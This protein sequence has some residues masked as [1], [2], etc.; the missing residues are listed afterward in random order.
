MRVVHC[1]V[2]ISNIAQSYHRMFWLFYISSIIV[3]I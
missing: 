2:F 3:G 1:D